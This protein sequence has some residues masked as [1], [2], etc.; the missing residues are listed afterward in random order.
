MLRTQHDA[1]PKRHV[2]GS[3]RYPT[4]Q[5]STVRAGRMHGNCHY[6]GF[7]PCWAI[8]HSRQHAVRN[9]QV[10]TS[11]L[12]CRHGAGRRLRTPPRRARIRQLRLQALR[13]SIIT[14]RLSLTS[15]SCSRGR[16]SS[17]RILLS[18]PF[19]LLQPP[20]SSQCIFLA[21]RIR[22]LRG[23]PPPRP[24]PLSH[25]T[26]HKYLNKICS[27]ARFASS[28]HAALRDS[29]P[30]LLAGSQRCQRAQF[31]CVSWW[32]KKRV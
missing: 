10:C 18:P 22:R 26:P 7:D 1:V 20:S 21:Q 6:T 16:L 28:G 30:T 19:P 17:A 2:R 31:D 5:D 23:A 13:A 12:Q 32:L 29:L 24:L 9:G 14:P 4:C 25:S 11:E 15:S 3:D 27:N 8:L